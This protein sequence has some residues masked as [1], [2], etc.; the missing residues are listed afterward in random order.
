MKASNTG[1]MHCAGCG[2]KSWILFWST[3][4]PGQGGKCHDCFMADKPPMAVTWN[5]TGWICPRCLKSNAPGVLS[6]GCPPSPAPAFVNSGAMPPHRVSITEVDRE[7]NV[8]YVFAY[9]PPPYEDQC[10][11]DS[12]PLDELEAALGVQLEDG[13]QSKFET[14]MTAYWPSRK[15][16]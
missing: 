7:R 9:L 16:L 1:E 8:A 12:Y 10:V 14:F 3:D 11:N 13:R 2:K 4:P 6:C 5:A 15:Q